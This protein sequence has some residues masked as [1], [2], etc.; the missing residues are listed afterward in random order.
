M[1]DDGLYMVFDDALKPKCEGLA[2]GDD[3]DRFDGGKDGND[4]V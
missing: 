2:N 4:G 3:V 1:E